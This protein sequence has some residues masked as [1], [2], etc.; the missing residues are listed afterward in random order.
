[1]ACWRKLSWSGGCWGAQGGH[2][3]AT[4]VLMSMGARSAFPLH[5]PERDRQENRGTA[6]DRQRQGERERDRRF[7]FPLHTPPASPG[8]EFISFGASEIVLSLVFGASEIVLSLVE[9]I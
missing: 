7:A 3:E 4:D 5:T 2:E 9:Y 1:M 8:Q 6:T